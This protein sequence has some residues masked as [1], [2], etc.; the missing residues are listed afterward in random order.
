MKKIITFLFLVFITTFSFAQINDNCIN[1]IPLCNTP[2]FTFNANSG[3]G[4]VIDFSTSST[5][6]NPSTNPNPP[7]G[8]CLLQGELNPQ[9]LLITIG[10]AGFL[11][12]VFGAANSLH[13]QA[14]CY[15][16]SM[17]PYS[18]TTCAD[19]LNNTL[20]PIRC[21]WNGD[22]G[23]KGT[24]IA[25]PAN[26][27]VFGGSAS[28]FEAPLAVNAC[29]Q[30]IICISN[31]SG[32]NTLVSFQSLG[33]A[34]LSCN[35]NCNPNYAICSG[36]S[37]TIVPVNFAALTNPSYSIQPGGTTNTTGSFVVTPTVTSSYT[38]YITGTN[39][40]NAVQ[41]ITSVSTVTVNAQPSTAPTLTQT[42]C[43][44]TLN[45]V[46][47]NVT[48]NPPGPAPGYSVTWSP[49]PNVV[50]LPS[51][52]SFTG[53]I[54]PGT[55]NATITTA[56]GCVTQTNVTINPPPAPAIISLI[57]LNTSHTIT[58]AQ[59]TVV[60]TSLDAASN[61]TWSNG[62]IAPI[63]GTVAALTSTAIGSWT[64][65]AIHAT[66]GCVATKTFVVGLDITAPTTAVSPT[67][68]TINCNL[69][70]ITQIVA[71]ANPTV[72]ITH[73]IISP[74][75]GTFSAT[76]HTLGYMP[77]GVGIYTHCVVNDANGC[78]SCKTFTVSSNQGFPT[79]SVVSAENFT[80]GCGTR[81][82]AVINIINGNTT[83]PGGAISYTLI[84]PGSP[85]TI[86]SGS[87]SLISTYTVSTPGTW[88]VV[89]KD[90]L[91][92]CET[93]NAI[94]VLSN[95]FAPDISVLVPRLVV[96]CNVPRITLKGQSLTQNVN[97]IW[98]FPGTPGTQPGD[99]LTAYANFATPNTSVVANFTL[100]V[101]DNNS[102]CKSNTVVP[103]RQ[104]LYPPIAIISNGGTFS[105]SC[106]TGTIMLTNLSK[107]GIPQ[108]T[109]FP[110]NQNVIGYVWEGP[111]PQEPLQINST[112]LAG[113]VG[114]Y[115]LTAKDLNNGC[116]SKTTTTI[117]DNR[118]YPQI[119]KQVNPSE[120]D[121]GAK[122][123]TILAI[124]TATAN[125]Y[126]YDWTA[127]FGA[128]ISPKPYTQKLEVTKIGLYRVL[129]TDAAT[130]C[131]SL[132]EI[133]VTNGSL[134]ALLDAQ[135]EKGFAPLEVNFFNNSASTNTNPAQAA[136][137]ITTYWNF[138]NGTSS[139][140]TSSNLS[141]SMTYSLPG[142]YN[143]RMF[144]VKG[145]CLDTAYKTIVVD[146]PSELTIPNVFTPNGDG[147][148]DLFF[149][150]STNLEEISIL[151][152]DRWG[153]K[154]YDLV[155]DKGNIAWD[156]KN[157]L[158]KEVADGTYFYLIKATGKDGLSYDK[159]GTVSLY[160]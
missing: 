129:I 156:G 18:P 48:F 23:P 138:A 27:T 22:C 131:A 85:T 123:A 42:S 146:I 50:T 119:V 64:I 43:T 66:S 109:G 33:T 26:Y 16:W 121:C 56:A 122:S 41:T 53:G 149:L 89:T 13:P 115:T 45:G 116:T 145:N 2:S 1:A 135:P 125:T 80:L 114:V 61:Y 34:S 112:Y 90:N 37:A 12:F 79:Y 15:D 65:T 71:S 77:G 108:T 32:V 24:G 96:D 69:S 47:L 97:Y 3:P 78:S 51:Q 113:T 73:Q 67:F 107:T 106:K 103:I 55:Y 38:T 101:T 60:I 36:A 20:P 40:V 84:P 98:S 5:I 82:T 7:N 31:Y 133:T 6:S 159:K 139:V 63:T 29:Q 75:G 39:L 49:I 59:P 72:N 17:W 9:W 83:P 157:Q 30:F 8:G 134:T 94:S 11:E 99:T 70:S 54:L 124:T 142:T 137:G 158:G 46:D 102:T 128:T 140:T 86:P 88:T 143:V 76:S 93:R 120:L 100:T 104:N 144:V 126:V 19:I 57:P 92:L 152:Y 62:I 44:S 87:L 160:R 141:P 151:I 14:G 35:P 52:T 110:D 150:K 28:N 105:I 25:S 81:S 148:N 153:H 21:N 132:G 130:G 74:Q 10:N 147:V 68:Q 91:S 136:A 4:S 155:S 154:V 118:I 95:T 111:S 58:C 117:G 127:P